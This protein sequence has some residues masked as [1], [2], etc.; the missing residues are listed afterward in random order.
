MGH[1]REDARVFWHSHPRIR[2]GFQVLASPISRPY[3]YCKSSARQR[4]SLKQYNL[5]EEA[6][7]RQITLSRNSQARRE[8]ALRERERSP[9][10]DASGRDGKGKT[11]K[12]QEQSILFAKL[13]GELR[14]KIWEEVL[15]ETGSLHVYLAEDRY[16]DN[17]LKL[18]SATCTRPEER[19]LRLHDCIYNENKKHTIHLLLACKRM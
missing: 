7:Q 13:P 10:A 16:P 12:E 5:T 1:F 15:C 3:Q 14:L 17:V 11:R 18:M 19:N 2:N 8:R 4:K 9:G 6:R